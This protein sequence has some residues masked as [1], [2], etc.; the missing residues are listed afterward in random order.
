M[1]WRDILKENRLVSQNITH[2]KV[3]ENKPEQSDD[4]CRKRLRKFLE[5][6]NSRM[7]HFVTKGVLTWESNV[8][9]DFFS[10]ARLAHVP[11]QSCCEIIEELQKIRQGKRLYA[12]F[13]FSDSHPLEH[14]GRLSVKDSTTFSTL[15]SIGNMPHESFFFL[16]LRSPKWEGFVSGAS[17]KLAVHDDIINIFESGDDRMKRHILKSVGLIWKDLHDKIVEILP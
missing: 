8:W 5:D 10:I 9:G 12:Q 15:P 14:G 11:E 4:R 2:T 17:F 13:S 1:T 6:L 3:D 7:E 16:D